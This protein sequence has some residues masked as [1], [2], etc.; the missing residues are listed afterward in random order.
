MAFERLAGPP[1]RAGVVPAVRQ[2]CGLACRM[3]FASAA[4]A[5]FKSGANSVALPLGWPHKDFRCSLTNVVKFERP[6]L[7]LEQT[8]RGEHEHDRAVSDC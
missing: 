2:S 3:S 8:S 7:P 6:E 4:P 1:F 5:S